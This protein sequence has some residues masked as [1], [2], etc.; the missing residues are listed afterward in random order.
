MSILPPVVEPQDE[1]AVDAWYAL[2]LATF[3]EFSD[4]AVYDSAM[5]KAWI[6][7][8]ATI[9][10]PQVFGQQLNLAVCL[11]LAHNVV[12]EAREAKT[13]KGGG[14]VGAATGPVASKS[15]DKLSIAY[16]AAATS[17]DGGAFNLTSYGIRL[18]QMIKGFTAGPF[19]FPSPR[20]RCR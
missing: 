15:I 4:T 1:G 6:V 17:D 18:W 3:P 5:V 14:I 13:A 16:S 19:Y 12:L 8:A 2:F 9:V 7:P 11:W 20:R 10:S